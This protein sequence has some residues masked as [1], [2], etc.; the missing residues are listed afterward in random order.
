[1]NC[2]WVEIS[3][4][5]LRRDYGVQFTIMN[6]RERK[7]TG[8]V[9]FSLDGFVATLCLRRAFPAYLKERGDEMVMKKLKFLG[10][11]CILCRAKSCL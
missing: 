11:L 10:P 3:S 1:M 6:S 4:E 5:R 8:S 2:A 9:F 7:K